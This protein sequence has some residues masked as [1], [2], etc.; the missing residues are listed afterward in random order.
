MIRNLI[1]HVMLEDFGVEYPYLTFQTKEVVKQHVVKRIQVADD[2]IILQDGRVLRD[3]VLKVEV[4][5]SIHYRYYEGVTYDFHDEFKNC[6]DDVIYIYMSWG[7]G[8]TSSHVFDGVWRYSDTGTL[9]NLFLHPVVQVGQRTR[10]IHED[11]EM[12]WKDQA[13]VNSI[14]HVMME[15]LD[16]RLETFSETHSSSYTWKRSVINQTEDPG[17]YEAA[18]LVSG[19]DNRVFQDMWK[20]IYRKGA[21]REMTVLTNSMTQWQ[22]ALFER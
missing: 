1:Q 16:G 7:N 9:I 6:D 10:D 12:A 3:A 20:A 11:L 18:N 19:I 15:A 8:K 14:E 13:Y 2:L 22:P 17:Y 21:I 4:D 5:G